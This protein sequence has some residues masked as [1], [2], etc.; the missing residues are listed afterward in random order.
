MQCRVKYRELSGLRT[1]ERREEKKSKKRTGG[2]AASKSKLFTQADVRVFDAGIAQEKIGGI[3]GGVD[4]FDDTLV[5]N[6]DGQ[7]EDEHGTYKVCFDGYVDMLF[8]GNTCW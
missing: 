7:E 6:G 5:E 1:Q 2:S 3:I 8:G 4:A